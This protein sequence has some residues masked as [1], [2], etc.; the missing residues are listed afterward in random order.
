MIEYITISLNLNEAIFEP[1]EK[2]NCT[3]YTQEPQSQELI[4]VIPLGP[5][6]WVTIVPDLSVEY[7]YYWVNYNISLTWI[8]ATNFLGDDFQWGRSEVVIIYPD[9]YLDKLQYFIDLKTS[10][11]LG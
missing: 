4:L 2:S 6:K 11:I 8:K 3:G 1:T 10:A 5:S 7:T 9:I